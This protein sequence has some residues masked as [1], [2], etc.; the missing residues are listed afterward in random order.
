LRDHDVF[1]GVYAAAR[2]FDLF[3]KERRL[4]STAANSSML[5]GKMP[6]LIIDKKYRN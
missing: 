5:C 2:L 1:Q 6:E 4:F 3:R